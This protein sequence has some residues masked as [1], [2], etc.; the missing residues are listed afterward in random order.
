MV[1]RKITDAFSDRKIEKQ[2]KEK[3]GLMYAYT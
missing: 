3:D 1:Y 2:I